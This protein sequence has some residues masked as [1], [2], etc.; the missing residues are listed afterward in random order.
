M[1]I[2]TETKFNTGDRI[3]GINDRH[4]ECKFTC[5]H[6]KSSATDYHEVVWKAMP[7]M[8]LI[9]GVEVYFNSHPDEGQEQWTVGYRSGGMLFQADEVFDTL[10]EAQQ[11][12]VRRNA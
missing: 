2:E 11:E 12:V 9:T 7:S 6:G 3:W 8:V 1:K 5:P 4:I 10:V